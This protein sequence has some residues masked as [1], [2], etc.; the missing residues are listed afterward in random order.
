VPSREDGVAAAASEVVGGPVGRFAVVGRRGWQ[1][2]AVVLMALA[3]VVL[4]GGVLEKAHC[5]M[6]GWSGTDQFWHACYSDLPVVYTTSGLS[7]GVAPYLSGAGEHALAQPIL[8]GLAMWGVGDLVPAGSG[9]LRQQQWY[10]GIWAGLVV[11]LLALLVLVT[12]ATVD[13]VPW[14][15]AHVA[16]S[17]LLV[18]VALVSA[19]LFGVLLASAGIWAWTK[20]RD[21]P[22]GVL[23]GLAVLARSYPVLVV[24]A[25]AM[26]ALRDGE[27]R[28]LKAVVGATLATVAV[29]SIPW[30]VVDAGGFLT[31]YHSW[32]T[33][34][35]GYG[36]PWLIPQLLGQPLP[37][38]A[39]TLLALLGWGA[40]LLVG[41]RLAWGSLTD[42]ATSATVRGRVP[43]VVPLAAVMVAIVLV[44]GKSLPVQSSLWLLPLVALAGVRWRDHLVWAGLECG[45][46]VGVWLYAPIGEDPDRAI[47]AHV[48]AIF[49]VARLVG[50][51]WVA[52]AAW[53][54]PGRP[55]DFGSEHVDRYPR[56]GSPDPSVD[57]P[58]AV[59]RA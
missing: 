30:L 28:R 38:G 6:R 14:R 34:A 15:A 43:G 52:G 46:F 48:Y 51:A 54:G 11:V 16:L 5:L 13:D 9:V 12:A 49:L 31:A 17:P 19:D 27:R 2:V 39:T 35:A 25:V 1:P 41:A 57:N 22:A 10:F 20:R 56:A 7:E 4:A 33:S 50:I 18:T 21:V 58:E 37:G 36:S 23:L 47:P 29:V 3:S 40:A 32:W 26:V 59:T 42:P 8:T 44:T 45:Y 55:R 24:V 53:W